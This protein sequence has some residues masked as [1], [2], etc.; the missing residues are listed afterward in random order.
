MVTIKTLKEYYKLLITSACVW[1]REYEEDK[2]YEE[3]KNGIKYVEV[4]TK[5]EKW[6]SLKSTNMN[7]T[8]DDV[9][10]RIL[11]ESEGNK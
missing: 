6:L 2:E 9:L 1:W 7:H 8:L 10:H 4:C 11:S 5:F 3:E